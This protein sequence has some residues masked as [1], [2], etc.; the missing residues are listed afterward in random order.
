LHASKKDFKMKIKFI[1]L[2]L[3]LCG[4]P[5]GVRGWAVH[6]GQNLYTISPD[7]QFTVTIKIAESGAEI[8]ALGFDLT[9]PADL[10]EYQS[11]Q[12]VA[13]DLENWEF[14]NAQLLAAGRVR[15]AGFTVS[16]PITAP[17]K[18]ALVHLHF[19]AKSNAAGSGEII[20]SQFTD[21]LAAATTRPSR[22]EM[23]QSQWKII[24]SDSVFSFAPDEIFNLSLK[25]TGNGKNVAA[26]GADLLVPADLLEFQ[27][28]DFTGTLLEKW[29]Y[30]DARLLNPGMLRLAGFTTENPIS[31]ET[32][33]DWVKLTFRVRPAATGA[34]I[35]T[36]LNLRDDLA[37]ADPDTALFQTQPRPAWEVPIR[38]TS[39]NFRDSL[40]FAG[41]SQATL[42]YDPGIDRLTPPPG[43]NAYCFF[44]IAEM[45]FCLK[46]DARDWVFPFQTAHDWVLKL[47]NFPEQPTT[48]DWNP[49]L[50]PPDGYF[51]LES[52]SGE[53]NL[54]EVA[55]LTLSGNQEVK[56]KYRKTPESA[57]WR[58]PLTLTGNAGTF[59][60]TLGGEIAAQPGFDPEFDKI[61]PPPGMEFYA[62]FLTE[63]FPYYLETDI[64][65]WE[66]PF[67]A[68][69][70]WFLLVTNAGDPNVT[71]GWDGS[72][73]PVWGNFH[74]HG[75]PNPVNLRTTHAVSCLGNQ[76][77]SIIYTPGSIQT[78]QTEIEN[79]VA[80][81]FAFELRQN[82]P[83]PFNPS[84]TLQFQ[85]PEA[86][87]V[88]LKIFNLIGEEI[89]TLIHAEQNAG[90]HRI[91]W[92][93]TND[94][95]LK[96]PSGI[97]FYQLRVNEFCLTRKMI[98]ME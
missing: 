15:V 17:E 2:W 34:G 28:V 31:G 72:R 74:L 84:T 95:G 62:C 90:F 37:D 57:A 5:Q 97:Y 70:K 89:R 50:L 29:S 4:L 46:K 26:F 33:C 78:P 7:S 8:A 85:L 66:A 75:L 63:A 11:A 86:G 53:L 41:H 48:L 40:T 39:E 93:G 38:I 22:V 80:R 81:P 42:S 71:L 68:V 91:I 96:V 76:T 79:P 19:L 51:F 47:V 54:R 43:M 65:N 56:I 58:L 73:L 10:I 59:Q 30:R 32:D 14:K 9:F 67:E 45:P 6:P 23:L 55:T 87:A 60:L 82:F 25:L 21:H 94:A 27:A 77:L 18:G 88:S 16:H 98:F 3:A 13:T 49:E 92:N 1:I 61:A 83:N 35:L 12:F 69:Q 20:L 36:V 24:F 52:A 64:R 44:K